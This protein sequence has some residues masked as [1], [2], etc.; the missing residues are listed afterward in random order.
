MVGMGVEN[1]RGNVEMMS[2][3]RRSKVKHMYVHILTPVSPQ[4]T[5]QNINQHKATTGALELGC[6]ALFIIYSQ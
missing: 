4:S 1:K 3:D 2:I 6:S 5:D